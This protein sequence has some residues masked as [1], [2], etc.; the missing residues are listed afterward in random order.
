MYYYIVVFLL[1]LIPIVFQKSQF[2]NSNNLIYYFILPLFICFGYMTGSDWRAYEIGFDEILNFKD[3]FDY[4][5]EI[6]YSLLGYIFKIIGLSFWQYAITVKL[7]GYYIFLHIYKKY[8]NGNLFGLLFFYVNFALF[9]WIDH[10]ARNFCAI[11]IYLF[12]FKY[13]YEKSLPKYLL[14]CLLASFFHLSALFLMPIYIFNKKYNKKIYLVLVVISIVIFAVSHTFLP[15][16]SS[17]FESMFFYNRFNAY[18]NDAYIGKSMNVF[19]F[20]F[21]V[22][23]IILAII[24]Q[25]KIEKFKYGTLILNLSIVY[26]LFFSIGNINV[27]LFRFNFYYVVPFT[28]LL[29]YLFMTMQTA[30]KMLFKYTIILIS[31][32]Y[33]LDLITKDYRYV[34]YTNYIYYA[35][36]EKPS[37]SYRSN[38]NFNNSPYLNP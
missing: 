1:L 11:V 32:Y 33:M 30:I 4:S 8:S 16:I 22:I 17:L 38:Y 35:F 18:L 24:N 23:I 12:S 27:I 37:Y 36:Y 7:I 20:A 29:T 19:R 34:P 10:P 14:V 28:L 13:I 31:F 25:N 3:V 6:G 26:L 5:K 9:L 15:Y 21:I 2:K